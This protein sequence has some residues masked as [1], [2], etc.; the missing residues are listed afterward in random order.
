MPI[1]V[2]LLPEGL[3]K[4]TNCFLSLKVNFFH[5]TLHYKKN[6]KT[7][8]TAPQSIII[9]GNNHTMITVGCAQKD[10]CHMLSITYGK[11]KYDLREKESGTVATTWRREWGGEPGYDRHRLSKF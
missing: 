4:F 10:T 2:Y 1:C 8:N 6:K 9:L 3:Y 11:N 7:K 5:I